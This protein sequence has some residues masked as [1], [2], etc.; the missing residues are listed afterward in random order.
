[1]ISN[2][3]LKRGAAAAR[4]V[5]A[6][7]HL[8]EPLAN[9]TTAVLA[10]LLVAALLL[11]Q[12][13]RFT[14]DPAVDARGAHP[15]GAALAA[16]AAAVATDQERAYGAAR[17]DRAG[18]C[19][20]AELAAAAHREARNAQRAAAWASRAAGDC[21]APPREPTNPEPTT[22][23]VAPPSG[24]PS[25]GSDLP[26]FAAAAL[27]FAE[28]LVRGDAAAASAWLC[29]RL[30]A[31]VS[32]ADLARAYARMLADDDGPMGAPERVFVV[33]TLTEWPAKQAGD[34][35]WAYV[36][37][38]GDAYSEAV[39]VVV[40]HVGGAPRIREIEWGRP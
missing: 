35:G 40:A 14:L 29:P 1:M 10:L 8:E 7:A 27:A 37:I 39:A 26:A 2:L 18:R 15:V 13:V 22:P 17:G 19:A 23:M 20:A 31:R 24:A 5:S 9:P 30:A 11:L 4:A 36:A 3:A 38:E 33:N 16:A 6:P 34:L 25:A 21:A 12:L 32:A 28:A